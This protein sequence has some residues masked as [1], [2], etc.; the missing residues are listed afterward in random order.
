MKDI[1]CRHGFRIVYDMDV[2]ESIGDGFFF[3]IGYG[4][5]TGEQ[6]VVELMY[7]GIS[8]ISLGT[9]GSL[10]NG[11]RACVSRMREELFPVLEERVKAFNRDHSNL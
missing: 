11:V 3:T 6:L 10:Q 2:T 5:M 8:S 1:F 4:D 9:T 7:Y